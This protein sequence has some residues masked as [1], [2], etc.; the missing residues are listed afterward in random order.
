M[1]EL[2][3]P[4]EINAEEWTATPSAVRALVVSLLERLM[5]LGWKSG[6]GYLSRQAS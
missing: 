5:R 1:K 3:P 6:E 4:A 2:Q